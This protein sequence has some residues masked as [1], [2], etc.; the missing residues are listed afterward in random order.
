MAGAEMILILASTPNMFLPKP[1]LLPPLFKRCGKCHALKS[2]T[3]QTGWA[4]T[5]VYF[6][7]PVISR[8]SRIRAASLKDGGN[9][10]V[11]TVTGNQGIQKAGINLILKIGGTPR[12]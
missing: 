4:A 1:S 3:C 12:P 8:D 6:D 5:A 10:R 9:R 11:R 7:V 2:R